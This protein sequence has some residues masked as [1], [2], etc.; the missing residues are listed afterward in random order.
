MTPL[1]ST[2]VG[3]KSDSYPRSRSRFGIKIVVAIAITIVVA[4][5]CGGP[6]LSL[7]SSSPSPSSSQH[8]HHHPHTQPLSLNII[9]MI[10]LIIIIILILIN[11]CNT[12]SY[13]QLCGACRHRHGACS[14]EQVRGQAPQTIEKTPMSVTMRRTKTLGAVPMTEQAV[15]GV[16]S[17]GKPRAPSQRQVPRNSATPT[18]SVTDNVGRAKKKIN[19]NQRPPNGSC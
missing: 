17:A 19:I 12:S 10:V 3:I 7:Q 15:W 14:C 8:L 6:S 16:G 13:Y 1:A 4:S 2:C 18:V 5:A 11:I 9:I